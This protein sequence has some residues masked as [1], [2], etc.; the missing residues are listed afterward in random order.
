MS[1]G[2]SGREDRG[3]NKL[4]WLVVVG[5]KTSKPRLEQ[6]LRDAAARVADGAEWI[7]LGPDELTIEVEGP[8][9]LPAALRAAP[10]VKDVYPSSEMSLY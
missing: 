8:A 5:N 7:E 9:D 3:P 4:R 6:R 1:C 2:R 10:E